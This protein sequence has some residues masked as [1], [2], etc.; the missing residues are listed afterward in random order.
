MLKNIIHYSRTGFIFL[1]AAL[2][3]GW[4]VVIVSGNLNNGRK[5]GFSFR[6]L[7]KDSSNDNANNSVRLSDYVKNIKSI[8]PWL[9]PKQRLYKNKK[10]VKQLKASLGT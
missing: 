2:S 3:S 8:K 7:N 9:L 10:L 1:Q 6:K 5:A 4:Q